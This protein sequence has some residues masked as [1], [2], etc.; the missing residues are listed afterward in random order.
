MLGLASGPPG[1]WLR[2]TGVQK[3]DALLVPADR[4]LFANLVA[5]PLKKMLLK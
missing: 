4:K 2:T 3:T 1:R 5:Y